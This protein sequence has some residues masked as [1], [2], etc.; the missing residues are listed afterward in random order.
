MSRRMCLMIT[1]VSLV[2]STWLSA[3]GRKQPAPSSQT[4]A[5][6]PK[7]VSGSL[8]PGMLRLEAEK[9]RGLVAE[10]A[11]KDLIEV[12][13]KKYPDQWGEQQAAENGGLGQLYLNPASTERESGQRQAPVRIGAKTDVQIFGER[14][15]NVEPTDK[16]YSVSEN[17]RV[18]ERVAMP[19]DKAL[20]IEDML[21]DDAVTLER[22]VTDLARLEI[23]AVPMISR[24]DKAN[25]CCEPGKSCICGE[26]KNCVRVSTLTLVPSKV[27]ETRSQPQSAASTARF[28]PDSSDL[29]Q[30]KQDLEREAAKLIDWFRKNSQS[31]NP[32]GCF[33]EDQLLLWSEDVP[34][35]LKRWSS[36][37][38]DVASRIKQLKNEEGANRKDLPPAVLASPASDLKTPTAPA[39]VKK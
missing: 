25:P 36:F 12:M 4:S 21:I 23:V 34:Q 13:K 9:L 20:S 31:D 38:N 15:R 35:G 37:W 32:L 1:L 19:P 29:R 18:T 24:S 17:G 6:C 10:T 5:G 16:C 27:F 33:S 30:A 26:E 8:G 3:Q 28:T 22:C 11:L 7:R 14:G 2:T 39:K